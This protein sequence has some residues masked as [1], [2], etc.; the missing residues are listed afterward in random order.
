M[1][2]YM[3]GKMEVISIEF[4]Q[5]RGGF[6]TFRLQCV[7]ILEAIKHSLQ[8]PRCS[9][10]GVR[11]AVAASFTDVSPCSAHHAPYLTALPPADRAAAGVRTAPLT[12]HQSWTCCQS[13][14]SREYTPTRA[15]VPMIHLLKS[16]KKVF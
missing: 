15:C 2:E 13:S 6:A 11:G 4:S 12:T 5:R 10:R 7:F 1:R 3:R 14:H 9:G 8:N 16:K